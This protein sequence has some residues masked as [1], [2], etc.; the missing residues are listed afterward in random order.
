MSPRVLNELTVMYAESFQ[1]STL[2]ERYTPAQYAGVGSARYV[3]PSLSWGASP[4]TAFRN[5]YKQFRDAVSVS[6]GSHNWKFGVGAQILPTFQT[7]PGS[8]YGTWTFGTDQFFDP[9]AP[10]SFANLKTAHAVHCGAA[11]HLAAEPE[12]HLRRRTCRTSGSRGRT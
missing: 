11:G 7:S 8:P 12:P 6:A 3:F 4:G 5:L 10:A 9:S 1:T 2:S